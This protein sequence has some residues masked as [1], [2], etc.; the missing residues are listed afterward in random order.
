[1][2]ING[3]ASSTIAICNIGKPL[4]ACLE[5][6]CLLLNIRRHWMLA[7]LS[8]MATS[9]GDHATIVSKT[10]SGKGFN[11]PGLA[12]SLNADDPAL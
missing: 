6:A 11:I 4:F 3:L 7:M 9:E 1:M 5:D 10:S 8:I 2:L 12:Y